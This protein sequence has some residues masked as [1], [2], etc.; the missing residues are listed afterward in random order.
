VSSSEALAAGASFGARPWRIVRPWWIG[1]SRGT[2]RDRDQHGRIGSR[3]WWS[4]MIAVLLSMAVAVI[5]FL[6]L[7][8]NAWAQFKGSPGMVAY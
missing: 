2:G 8:A 6:G 5:V 1:A 3:R 4:A 7:A